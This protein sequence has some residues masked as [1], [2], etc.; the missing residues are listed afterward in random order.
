M[1]FDEFQPLS[2]ISFN[3]IDLLDT[4]AVQ[5]NQWF[6]YK[7]QKRFY[8][9]G[10]LDVLNK[11]PVTVSQIE[12]CCREIA[13]GVGEQFSRKPI[14]E[15]TLGLRLSFPKVAIAAAGTNMALQRIDR[16]P[17]ISKRSVVASIFKV[18]KLRTHLGTYCE[19]AN[20]EIENAFARLEAETAIAPGVLQMMAY[21]VL[22]D[23]ND[24]QQPLSPEVDAGGGRV[25][26]RTAL[27]VADALIRI[28]EFDCSQMT[29]QDLVTMESSDAKSLSIQEQNVST[30]P[31]PG[32]PFG[33]PED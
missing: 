27:A 16:E 28:P 12:S 15:L 8:L 19:R 14:D 20:T 24:F 30:D 29:L 6:K 5:S 22:S 1:A 2:G 17:M 26:V 25:V 32:N 18:P 9:P 10:I 31:I 33:W 13:V 7:Q 11:T 23:P 21:G 4:P 3:C